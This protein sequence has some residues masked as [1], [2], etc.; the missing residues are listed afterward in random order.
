MKLL[1]SRPGHNF[2]SRLNSATHYGVST[3]QKFHS[4]NINVH[5]DCVF[6]HR[7]LCAGK[8]H[9]LYIFCSVD[10]C[11]LSLI[12]CCCF[13]A[14]FLAYKMMMMMTMMKIIFS[15]IRDRPCSEFLRVTGFQ[16]VDFHLQL[17]HLLIRRQMAEVFFLLLRLHA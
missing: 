13:S 8:L 17:F 4:Y 16:L 11:R 12:S 1:P 7:I 3:S 10:P 14:S 5:H 9:I 2:R 6:V 15:Q